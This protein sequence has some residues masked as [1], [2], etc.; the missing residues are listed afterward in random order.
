MSIRHLAAVVCPLSRLGHPL[1]VAPSDRSFPGAS[2]HAGS[3]IRVSLE[4]QM[5]FPASRASRRC[6]DLGLAETVE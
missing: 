5:P 3:V 2:L 4:I 6:R 1:P